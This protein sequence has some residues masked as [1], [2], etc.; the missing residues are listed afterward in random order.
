VALVRPI[1][2]EDVAAAIELLRGGSL[3]P[4]FE[5]ASKVDDYWSAVE[6]TRRQRGDVL[7]AEVDGDVVGVCQVIIFRHFQ[8][9]GGWCA[10]VESVHVRS[11]QRSQGIGAQLL[12]AA[13]ELA[14]ER[15]CYR[16]Q[17]T[18]RN[19]REDAHRFYRTNGYGQTS[20][21]FKKFFD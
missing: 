3:M 4:E 12:H 5:D 1:R 2:H 19:V 11:D 6:E 9:A 15:G 8:H 17:L 16:I 10:E 7:V 13:D 20:Q 21:G 18:S 14:K